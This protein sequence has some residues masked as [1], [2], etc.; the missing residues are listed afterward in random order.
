MRQSGMLAA[1]GL[2]ALDHHVAR[3]SDDHARA[4]RL[5][6]GLRGIDGVAVAAQQTN[7]VFI[8]VAAD[9]LRALAAHLDAHGVRAS[10]GYLPSVRL[11]THLDIDDAA[12]ERAIAVFRAFRA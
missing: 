5:A 9:R 4:A 1:A 6:D 12:L 11:V 10:I 8:D 3:L 2:H 7:M